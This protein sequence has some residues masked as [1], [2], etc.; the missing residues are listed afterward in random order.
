MKSIWIIG[1][2]HFGLRAVE[3]LSGK[4]SKM[5]I[6]VI[7]KDKKICEQIED[8]PFKVVCMD[9]V[10]YLDKNLKIQEYPD[11]IIPAIPVHLSYKWIRI[12]L[13]KERRLVTIE[14]PH[15]LIMTLPNPFKGKDGEIYI[16]NADFICPEN[17]PEPDEICTYTGKPRPKSL[18]KALESIQYNDF[19]SVV[20]QSRQL[21]P[22][23]GGYTPKA[24][25]EALTEITASRTPVLL[26][27]ACRCHG[28]MNAFTT[29]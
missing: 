28:V 1:A 14:V 21:L 10:T 25:F 8:M 12:K 3:L 26:S 9:G 24:L 2:G 5:D 13:P 18:Y 17:C 11:W 16:S 27:T 20:I 19:L 6:T 4:D 22:G 29:S 15:K 23:L 7:E